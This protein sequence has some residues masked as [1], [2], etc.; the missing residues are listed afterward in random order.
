MVLQKWGSRCMSDC[1]AES[2]LGSVAQEVEPCLCN[3]QS[4]T[5]VMQAFH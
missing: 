3:E 5:D 4:K 1:A 2:F